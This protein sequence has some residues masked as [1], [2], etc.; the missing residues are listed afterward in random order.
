[1]TSIVQAPGKQLKS[2]GQKTGIQ[3]ALALSQHQTILGLLSKAPLD[4][5]RDQSWAVNGS[6]YTSTWT[7]AL[8][9]DLLDEGQM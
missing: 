2:E 3:F 9:H 4:F 8:E 6:G 5:M 7:P 1:M